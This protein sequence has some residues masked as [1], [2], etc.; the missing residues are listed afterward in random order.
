MVFGLGSREVN[1]LR[2]EAMGLMHSDSWGFMDQHT[3]DFCTL[4]LPVKRFRE[5]RVSVHTQKQQRQEEKKS[6]SRA[7]TLL[8]M[9]CFLFDV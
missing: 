1:V 6:K 8:Y 2:F 7:V 9:V 4:L 5:M 3:D